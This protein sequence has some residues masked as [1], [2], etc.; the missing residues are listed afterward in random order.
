ML[1][2]QQQLLGRLWCTCLTSWPDHDG[3]LGPEGLLFVD[4]NLHFVAW[5]SGTLSKSEASG[6]QIAGGSRTTFGF[7]TAATGLKSTSFWRNNHP[8]K[9]FKAERQLTIVC[10]PAHY[11]PRA[12]RG[13]T[14]QARG[15]EWCG[16]V[17][18]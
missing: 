13:P 17:V 10:A 16:L 3:V 6:V 4:G 9:A 1:P 12:G 15:R 5:I 2:V 11:H 8:K 7:G 14:L 18:R